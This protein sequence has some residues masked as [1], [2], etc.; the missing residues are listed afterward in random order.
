MQVDKEKTYQVK[1]ARV[2]TV[3]A[4]KF[5][6]LGEINMTGE[7]L[8]QIIEQEGEEAIDGAEQV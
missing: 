2:V 4:F 5:K 8:A 6:P 7:L 3:G 1:L